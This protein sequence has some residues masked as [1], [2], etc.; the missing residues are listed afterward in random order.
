[1]ELLIGLYVN[2][3]VARRSLV[4]RIA[5]DEQGEGVVSAAIAV[6]IFAFLGAAMWVAFSGIFDGAADRTQEQINQIGS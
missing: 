3:D 4:E 6:L 2:A 5:K 1:M